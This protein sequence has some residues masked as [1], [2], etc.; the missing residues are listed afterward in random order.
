MKEILELT[1]D[2]NREGIKIKNG[3]E[4][5]LMSLKGV[6]IRSKQELSDIL[7]KSIKPETWKI[8]V[9]LANLVIL[10]PTGESLAKAIWLA[11]SKAK[12]RGP[13][14]KVLLGEKE[15]TEELLS[16]RIKEALEEK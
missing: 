8:L 11:I 12:N 13:Q 6:T 16:A 14:L 5:D 10:Y 9:D 4:A 1:V 2:F 7:L 15:V 3:L